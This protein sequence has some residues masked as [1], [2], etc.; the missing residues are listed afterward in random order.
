V[1]FKL[2]IRNHQTHPFDLFIAGV[3]MVPAE[4]EDIVS[5]FRAPKNGWFH[6]FVTIC[7]FTIATVLTHPIPWGDHYSPA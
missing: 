3:A 5:K 6:D 4:F 2:G 1:A 7:N